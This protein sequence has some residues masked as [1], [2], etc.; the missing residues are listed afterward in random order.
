MLYL[1]GGGCI[2][3]VSAIKSVGIFYNLGNVLVIKGVME[4]QHQLT[5]EL[6]LQSLFGHLCTALL[7]G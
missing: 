7:I 3:E 4:N 2:N 6:D 5:M 1:G